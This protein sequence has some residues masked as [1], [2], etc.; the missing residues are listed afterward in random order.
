MTTVETL[1]LHQL[2][3][4]LADPYELSHTTVTALD[5]I[6]VEATLTD[7]Q[8]GIG[9]VTTLH[10]YS[11]ESIDESWELLTRLG[12]S[13]PGLNHA[14]ATRTTTGSLAEYPFSRG[15]VLSA[16]E[17]AIDR[18]IKPVTAP[19]VGIT[20][21]IDPPEALRK[22][23]ADIQRGHDVIKVKIGFDPET[24]ATALNE[25]LAETPSTVEFRI[26]ANQAY[27]PADCR[28]L[29]D[30]VDTKRI[31]HIEQPFPSDDLE[32]HADLRNEYD[33]PVMLDESV[34][35]PPS[36]SKIA[37]RDAADKVKFK[38]MKQG[39]IRST[40]EQI[41][42]AN[43][44]GLGIVLGNGVQS[45]IGSVQEAS[46]WKRTDLDAVGEFNG[47]EKVTT[48]ILKE[49]PRFEDGSLKWEGGSL[50]LDPEKID[51]V[52]VQQTHFE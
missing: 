29:L 50:S 39:G 13:I 33:V 4:P 42:R 12:P 44:L 45:E 3:L 17:T 6:I 24:D 25:L 32:A 51:D 49:G 2:E 19:L 10:D 34:K 52:V 14:E 36:L 16:L 35:G 46:V 28:T 9:E 8:T 48:R 47:W 37:S 38:L 11:K 7:G 15:A 20:S 23:R 18:E 43:D 30:A 5:T 1:A 26:D 41:E 22:C 31:Q 40:T 27:S 21:A